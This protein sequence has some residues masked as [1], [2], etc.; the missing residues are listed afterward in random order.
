M[1][2][3]QGYTRTVH[4]IKASLGRELHVEAAVMFAKP[5]EN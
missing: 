2:E 4:T 5:P 3:M 1:G